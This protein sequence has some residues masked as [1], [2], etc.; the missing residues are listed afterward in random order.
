VNLEEIDNEREVTAMGLKDRAASII[1]FIAQSVHDG[2]AFG[3]AFG[4]C[5]NLIVELVV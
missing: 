3:A 4:R 2:L 5:M 1:I